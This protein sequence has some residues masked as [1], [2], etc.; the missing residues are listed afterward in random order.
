MKG[1]NVLKYVI[2]AAILG[3]VGLAVYLTDRAQD[4][5]GPVFQSEM[6][7]LTVSVTAGDVDLLAGLTAEDDT[8]G[9]VTDSIVIEQMSRIKADGSRTITYGAFDSSNNVSKYTR[10]LQYTDYKSPVF[11]LTGPLV[12]QRWDLNAAL[13]RI[14]VTDCIDGDITNK[15]KLY[16]VEESSSR[17]RIL[18]VYVTNSSGETVTQ[19][20]P[21]EILDITAEEYSE[22]PRVTLSQYLI[23][24]EAGEPE[25]DWTGYLKSVQVVEWL[26]EEELLRNV[27]D[28]SQVTIT[29]G[30][31]MENPG[32]YTVD[33]TYTDEMGRTGKTR[34]YVIVEE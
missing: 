32:I 24:K 5:T 18:T 7:V 11:S 9:D 15:M 8:D 20:F 17:S 4:Q 12:F 13:N 19:S 27:E 3:I 25:E 30:A 31:D 16:S 29:S 26:A 22:A 1:F 2:L 33:Y 14:R 6:D 28:L 23:Y 34:L 21:A 10:T